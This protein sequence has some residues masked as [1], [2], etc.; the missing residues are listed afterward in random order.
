M[1]AELEGLLVANGLGKH[2][3]RLSKAGMGT[4]DRLHLKRDLLVSLVAPDIAQQILAIIDDSPNGSRRVT[5]R[6]PQ[7]TSH[8]SLHLDGTDPLMAQLLVWEQQLQRKLRGAARDRIMFLQDQATASLSTT[9]VPFGKRRG[10][11]GRGL[12][13]NRD[14]C[15]IEHK[16]TLL[17]M[18]RTALKTHRRVLELERERLRRMHSGIVATD[19]DEQLPDLQAYVREVMI[20]LEQ[21]KH[22]HDI[23]QPEE[24]DQ[25]SSMLT[26]IE[27][28]KQENARL[29]QLLTDNGISPKIVPPPTTT[30]APTVVPQNQRVAPAPKSLAAQQYTSKLEIFQKLPTDKTPEQQ[31]KRRK[32]FAAFDPNGNG[33][34]SLAEI[35]K[36]CRDVLKLPQLFD[37]KP[38][39]IRAY[40]AAKNAHRKVQHSGEAD[41]FPVRRPGLDSDDYVE[42]PEFRLLL[43]YLKRYYLLFLIFQEFADGDSRIDVDEFL[44]AC[45]KMLKWGIEVGRTEDEQRKTFRLVDSDGQGMILFHE[46]ASWALK[47]GLADG[48]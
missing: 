31:E 9:N 7:S 19:I 18:C 34:L 4:V 21:E 11:A 33:F 26:E 28:L 42:L 13:A 36:G 24:A 1:S 23:G 37:A 27:R 43:L 20:A 10:R 40:T 15:H 47:L 45:P 8:A 46:F 35:D 16:K 41:E 12:A 3:S 6:P 25:S 48:E 44:R 29:S 22:L 17:S 14:G 30:E 39:L 38:V 32:L 2:Y 5:A